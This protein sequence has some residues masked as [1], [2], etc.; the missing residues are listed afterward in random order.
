MRLGSISCA[1]ADPWCLD[2]I[3]WSRWQ[4][5]K[6]ERCLVVPSS[7]KGE[8]VRS[9]SIRFGW[10]LNT[11]SSERSDRHRRRRRGEGEETMKSQFDKKHFYFVLCKTLE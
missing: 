2:F 7:R 3:G 4:W 1:G 10:K 6:Q 8:N 9:R 11:Q 5:V